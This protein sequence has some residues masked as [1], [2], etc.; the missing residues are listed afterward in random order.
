MR[1]HT[2]YSSVL[3]LAVTACGGPG[4]DAAELSVQQVQYA[5]TQ[6]H[7]DV[8][9]GPLPEGCIKIEGGQ[10]GIEGLELEL[11]GQSIT[12]SD[13]IAK[14]GSPGEYVGF[15]YETELCG[16]VSIKSGRDIDAE[17]FD[18]SWVN[19]NGTSGRNAKGISNIVFCSE[20]C[21]PPPPEEEEP[22]AE[23]PP[24]EEEPPAEEPPAEEPPHEEPP[25]EE[26][27]AEEP[28][29]EGVCCTKDIECGQGG[30]CGEDGYCYYF[31]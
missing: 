7:P 14:G 9:T 13:W 22:P 29:H 17:D 25:A 16:F 11:E 26:P 2:L 3:T 23:E 20:P 21:E 18:G 15:S 5:S 30:A 28:P 19:P 24:E 12:I 6:S 4:E 1:K 31:H 27:P 10:I 8:N